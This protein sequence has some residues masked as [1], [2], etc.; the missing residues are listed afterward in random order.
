MKMLTGLL[1]ASEGEALLFGSPVDA[2]DRKM[3]R[4]IGYMSQAFS[5]YGE[6]TVYQNLQLHARIFAIKDRVE[7]ID[8]LMGR[9]GLES[10]R[11]T[12][13]AA[14][15]L[16]IKQRL[17]LAVAVIHRPRVLI[18][19]EPTS[20]VDPEARDSFWALLVELS[21]KESVDDLCFDPFHGRRRSVVT[22]YP[23]C[24]RGVFW[25]KGRRMS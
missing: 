5:L 2:R 22:A 18:L 1:P 10:H 21:R 4:E 19:D 20:G 8:E 23:S 11:D 15:P 12:L 17:S 24:M 7:R 9:F 25:P 6:L 14:L 3:R 13:A 16:G